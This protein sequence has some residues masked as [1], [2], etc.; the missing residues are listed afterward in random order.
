ME[1]AMGTLKEKFQRLLREAAEVWVAFDQAEGTLA[2]VP[3]YAAI[4]A[5][6]HELGRQLGREIR[7]N[8]S[9]TRSAPNWSHAATPTP[10]PRPTPRPTPTL[11][12]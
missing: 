7:S 10:T 3:R 4:A 9:C 8:G 1:G 6:A 11:G 5:H 12:A 2:G